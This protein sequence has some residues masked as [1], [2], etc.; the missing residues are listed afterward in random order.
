MDERWFV[1]RSH[2]VAGESVRSWHQVRRVDVGVDGG[3]PLRFV[4]TVCGDR[5]V[6]G[7]DE[8]ISWDERPEPSCGACESAQENPE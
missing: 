7:G 5:F 2:R 6:H 3:Y 4:T 8:D 1:R